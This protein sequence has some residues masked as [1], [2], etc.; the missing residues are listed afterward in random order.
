[1]KK[2]LHKEG[3]ISL[4]FACMLSILIIGTLTYVSLQQGHSATLLKDNWYIP[5]SY[6]MLILSTLLGMSMAI[7][8]TY[9][10][11][12]ERKAKAA[13]LSNVYSYTRKYILDH[14]FTDEKQDTSSALNYLHYGIS[15]SIDFIKKIGQGDLYAEFDSTKASPLDLSNDSL[16]GSLIQ[17]RDQLQI[18]VEEEKQKSWV[19][20]KTLLFTSLLNKQYDNTQVF[21]FNVI[22]QLIHHLNA[23]QGGIYLVKETQDAE[24]YLELSACYAYSRMRF[25]QLKIRDG[26][27]PILQAWK[28]GKTLF[29]SSI[30]PHYKESI[31]GP[32]ATDL[33]SILVVPL[34]V[35]RK[36]I[37]V[38]EIT[39]T[40]VMAAHK[41]N[42]IQTL[43]DAIA[44]ALTTIRQ[45]EHTKRLM[46][47]SQ[48]ITEQLKS[49]E[50][51]V[52]HNLQEMMVTHDK[53]QHL[54]R[55]YKYM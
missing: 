44:T 53:L 48:A 52:R 25:Q 36:V 16:S 30:P 50:E 20:E 2:Y 17:M 37:G 27:S 41:L 19:T 11:I 10:V 54:C 26:E 47:A 51:E 29:I 46:Q 43:S 3:I 4:L 8:A 12:A 42:F 21:G 6:S 15:S 13:L 34:F 1:M 45:Q 40:E 24:D 28:E 32:T 7:H 39:S 31:Y 38:L 9:L 18:T 33:Q 55:C 49:Q 14:N 5:L 22:S 35:N 23:H